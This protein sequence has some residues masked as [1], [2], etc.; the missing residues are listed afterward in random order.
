MDNFISQFSLYNLIKK[1]TR[2]HEIHIRFAFILSEIFKTQHSL[3]PEF[4]RL[5]SESIFS[6]QPKSKPN[7]S[8]LKLF[9]FI[10]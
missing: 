1:P 6:T 8:N 3:N 2:F 9:V 7:F 10:H 4:V 5:L